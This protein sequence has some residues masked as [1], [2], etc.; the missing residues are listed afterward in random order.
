MVMEV[1]E[2]RNHW[3]NAHDELEMGNQWDCGPLEL[4]L[5]Q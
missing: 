4:I 2:D 3:C 5:V 1:G